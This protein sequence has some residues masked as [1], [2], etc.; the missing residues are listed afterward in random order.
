MTKSELFS[1]MVA[2]FASIAGSVMGVYLAMGIPATALLSGI[3]NISIKKQL[4]AYNSFGDVCTRIF[5]D[6]KNNVSGIRKIKVWT[7]E[8]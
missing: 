3:L 4:K 2:G 8:C 1:M 7:I 5:G 6:R